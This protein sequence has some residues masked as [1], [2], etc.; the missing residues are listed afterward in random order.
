MHTRQGFHDLAGNVIV[1]LNIDLGGPITRLV[2]VPKI[3]LYPLYGDTLA[4]KNL[5]AFLCGVS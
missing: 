1:T 5:A 4:I 3:N 2:V